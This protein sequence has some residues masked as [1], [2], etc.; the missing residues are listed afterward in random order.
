MSPDLPAPASPRLCKQKG[1]YG[2]MI[3]VGSREI[4]WEKSGMTFDKPLKVVSI[5]I[6]RW[7]S[8]KK[9]QISHFNEHMQ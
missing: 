5:S 9:F 2:N 7:L 4:V 3:V 8:H 6:L 1:C